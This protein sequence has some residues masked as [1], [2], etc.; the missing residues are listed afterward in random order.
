M[1]RLKIIKHIIPGIFALLF[2][3]ETSPAPL[4]GKSK[5]FTKATEDED[6]VVKNKLFPKRRRVEIAGPDVGAVL[7]QS[8]VASYVLH[9]NINYYWKEEW[10]FTLEGLFVIN[11]DKSERYCIENFYNDFENKV[12]ASCPVPGTAIDAPL[13]SGTDEQGNPVTVPGANFGPAYVPVRE[14]NY[15][16]TGAAV[17]NPVYGKQLAFLT[18]T[19]YFD[20]FI[21]IGGGLAFST[22]YPEQT[23]LKNG[24]L[25]RGNAPANIPDDCNDM[26]V[27]VCPDSN[28]THNN[29]VGING[30][31]P[32]QSQTTP[33]FTL[34]IGQKFHFKER[35]N[36][37]GEIRNYTLLGTE[38][39]FD[40][41]FMAWIGFGM[42]L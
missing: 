1:T 6:D 27:G 22:Y 24:K 18:R 4:F 13:Y 32:P 40:T 7:N 39:G 29:F 38:A 28:G 3:L 30:R 9:A 16:V 17:W 11:Q 10:G 14:L 25:S 20:L 31:P 21:T 33:T 34:G 37:K 19:V 12:A 23:I 8:Y 42:R 36:F 35:F 15:V 2:L 41:F 26:P 5:R